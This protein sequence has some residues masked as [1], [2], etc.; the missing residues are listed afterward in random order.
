M[1]NLFKVNLMRDLDDLNGDCSGHSNGGAGGNSDLKL[2]QYLRAQMQDSF[3][4]EKRFST[5]SR[6]KLKSHVSKK[7]SIFWIHFGRIR[8]SASSSTFLY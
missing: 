5:S 6:F 2:L 1:L 3:R 4:S 8:S 7:L